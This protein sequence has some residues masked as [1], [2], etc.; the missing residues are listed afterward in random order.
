VNTTMNLGDLLAS[1][2]LLN[3]LGMQK[4]SFEI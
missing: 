4:E 1:Q 3:G 2:G